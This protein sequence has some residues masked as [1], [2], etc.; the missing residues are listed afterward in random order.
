MIKTAKKTKKDIPLAISHD[1]SAELNRLNR[2]KGQIDGI[3]K[4]IRE[5][6]YCPD[7]VIQIKAIRSALRSLEANIVE[8]H[9]KHCV[10]TAIKSRD[11]KTINKKLEEVLLIIKGQG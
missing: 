1:H 4:M 10:T 8:S 5:N 7:I 2:I 6:R 3:D 9:I 11:Q